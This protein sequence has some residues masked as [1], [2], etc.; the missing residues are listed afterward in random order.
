VVVIAVLASVVPGRV[1]P[2]VDAQV[3]GDPPPAFVVVDKVIVGDAGLASDVTIRVQC[4]QVPDFGDATFDQTMTI[5]AGTTEISL[6]FGPISAPADCT[7]SETVDGSNGSASVVVDGLPATFRL[8][9]N[10]NY[11]IGVSNDVTAITGDLRVTKV[12]LGPGAPAR[13]DV[14]VDVAC[15]DPSGVQ[16]TTTVS[17]PPA[18]IVTRTLTGMVAN[19]E[20]VLTEVDDGAPPGAV[21]STLGSPNALTVV[22]G[23]TV[24]A[25]IVDVYRQ[26]TG[27]VQLVKVIDDPTG[28]RGAVVIDAVC[29]GTVV[30]TFAVPAGA[31]PFTSP[32]FDAPAGSTCAAVE[33]LDGSNAAVTAST[34]VAPPTVVVQSG[35]TSTLTVTDVYSATS[36]DTVDITLSKQLDGEVGLQGAVL[37]VANCGGRFGAVVVPAGAPTGTVSTVIADVPTGATCNVGEPLDGATDQVAVTT[38]GTGLGVAPTAG[39]VSVTNTYTTLPGSIRVQKSVGGPAADQRGPITLVISCDDGTSV[40]E[41]FGPADVPSDIVVPDLPAGTVCEVT[42]PTGGSTASV[43]ATVSGA[44]Q[45]VVVSPGREVL[46]LVDNRYE[47]RV[48]TLTVFKQT[49]GPA[50]NFRGLVE[51]DVTCDDGTTQDLVAGPLT[52]LVPVTFP[53]IPVGTSC[54]IDEIADGGSPFVDVVSEPTGPI[55]AT[56]GDG[57]SVVRITNTY[58]AAPGSLTVTKVVSGPGAALRGDVTINVQCQSVSDTFTLAAGANAPSSITVGGLF[59]GESCTV[60]EPATGAIAG[61]VDAAVSVAPSASIVVGPA[62]A[63]S[64]TLT[65]TYT[66]ASTTTT[67][68]TTTIAP[69]TSTSTTSAPTVPDSGG[70]ALPPTG[71][72]TGALAIASIALV[73]VGGALA[74]A[75]RRFRPNSRPSL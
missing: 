29:D 52:R 43:V 32:T 65:N 47:P 33:T 34:V 15:T 69:P 67:T 53:G 25:T 17:L 66:Q 74:A 55:V 57:V 23:D 16:T 59:P 38:V 1:T 2:T 5:P 11:G 56:I 58:T 13:G 6:T 35:S 44:P 71:F 28:A 19:S 26:A 72:G 7:V 75:R 14:V 42:E 51:V 31:G 40:T 12:S 46:A 54:T 61:V 9:P 62:Q 45:D 18:A 21:V 68:T 8:N 64:I 4:Q 70:G 37:L 48:G 73:G 36:P 63:V 27:S 22:A 10:E 39:V 49:R 41:T 50:G 30:G 3:V 60:T 20:C 24:G